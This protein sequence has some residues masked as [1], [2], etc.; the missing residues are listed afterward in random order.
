MIAVQIADIGSFM[1]KFLRSE[2]FDPFEFM[3]GTLQTRIT[4]DFDGHILSDSYSEDELREEG[5]FGHTYLP[6]SMQRPVLF[7]LIKGK[8]TPVFFK[9]TLF[10]PPSDFYERTQL[11]PDSSDADS[12]FLLNLRFTHGELTASTGVSYRTFSTDKSM[13]F[14]WDSYIRQFFKEHSLY[15]SEDL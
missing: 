2:I 7:D 9:F 1:T 4:Y 3:E 8:K 12:G 14:E 5:L 6:F 11:P 10:L 13:E 15:F